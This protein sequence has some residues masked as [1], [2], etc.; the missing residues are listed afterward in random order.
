M[1]QTANYTIEMRSTV[2]QGFNHYNGAAWQVLTM[3]HALN[4][5]FTVISV[6]F[7]MYALRLRF[8]GLTGVGASRK[9]GC[10]KDA[11]LDKGDASSFKGLDSISDPVFAKDKHCGCFPAWLISHIA[12]V[13]H[14]LL[15]VQ[16]TLGTTAASV[17]WL[18]RGFRNAKWMAIRPVAWESHKQFCGAV[19]SVALSFGRT[20]PIFSH[21]IFRRVCVCLFRKPRQAS[22]KLQVSVAHNRPPHSRAQAGLL[23][24]ALLAVLPAAQRV[25]GLHLAVHRAAHPPDQVP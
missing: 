5:Q 2:V 17:V 18:K 6:F 15:I 4:A 19:L 14:H 25:R 10:C 22:G 9:G 21:D 3:L 7:A 24:A 11:T 1:T 16:A 13:H 20:N 8:K 23:D 12:F